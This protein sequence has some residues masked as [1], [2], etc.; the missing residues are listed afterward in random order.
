M[1]GSKDLPAKV[2]EALKTSFTILPPGADLKAYNSEFQQKHSSSVPHLQA[3]YNVEYL[4]DNST[5]SQNESSLLKLLD[6]PSI[7]MAQASAS[8][9]LLNE[10][11][12]EEQ[13]KET[14]RE[15]A[16]KKWPEASI[17]Q[18]N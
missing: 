6:L 13:T 3:V 16:A 15:A 18:K 10:W 17:F 12:S 7:T 11:K 1:N 14:Y 8:L 2:E 9:D 4:L 5:K